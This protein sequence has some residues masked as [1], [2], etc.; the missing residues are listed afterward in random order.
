MGVPL[1]DW[2]FYVVTALALVSLWLVVKPFVASRRE[3]GGGGGGCHSCGGGPSATRRRRVTMTI[4]G[5]RV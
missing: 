4:R 3:G 2:Q 5:R 1:D